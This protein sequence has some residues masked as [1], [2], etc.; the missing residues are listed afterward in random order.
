[1]LKLRI[2]KQLGCVL[3]L[4]ASALPVAGNETLPQNHPLVPAQELVSTRAAVPTLDNAP[5][6]S[7]VIDLKK[8]T[9]IDGI[10]PQLSAKRVVFVGEIH[11]RHAHHETQLE[12]IRRLYAANP[13]LAIGMEWFQQPFQPE[14]DA[15]VAGTLNEK[16]L[17]KKTEYFTRWRV[18]FRLLRPILEFARSN[19]I[20]LI[21][22][23]IDREL[24]H[25][26][27][28]SGMEALTL[29]EKAKI[30][31]DIDRSDMQYLERLRKIFSSH[32]PEST[33]SFERMV[34][35]QL[36]WDESMA[37]RAAD[38]LKQH[39][40][41]RMAVLVGAG[42]VIYGSGIPNRLVR[43]LPAE[44][45]TILTGL[46]FG[47]NPE[48][49]DFLLLAEENPL[50]PSGKI[51]VGL[52]ESKKGVEITEFT[53]GSSAEAGGLRV[54][55]QIISIEGKPIEDIADLKISLLDKS[56]GE[57]LQMTVRRSG[58]LMGT[59]ELPIRV[60]LR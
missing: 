45:A 25:K 23:N 21:A 20:P 26:V 6:P 40:R 41:D 12:V 50:P 32:P 31:T 13:N 38:Y 24:H 22:L 1:M 15:Y 5:L 19:H 34:E 37:A 10:M 17:L 28:A 57:H 29:E 16:E 46:E 55:D 18:D 3:I 54:R 52:D 51:G 9:G 33:G 47:M 4:S 7:Q 35:G 2:S 39:P 11:D 36:L 8:L 53:P 42:H 56:P 30:P 27:V 58:W 43:R 44:T 60:T 48:V 59:E 49:A 14:L